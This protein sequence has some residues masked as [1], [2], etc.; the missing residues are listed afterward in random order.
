M[1]SS[2]VLAKMKPVKLTSTIKINSAKITEKIFPKLFPFG[3][4]SEKK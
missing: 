3:I 4:M 2:T 1:K